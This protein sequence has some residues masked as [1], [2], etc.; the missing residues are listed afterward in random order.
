MEFDSRPT[1]YDNW[2]TMWKS[3][4]MDGVRDGS[5]LLSN[6]EIESI[7]NAF[8]ELK[9]FRRNSDNCHANDESKGLDIEAKLQ[10]ILDDL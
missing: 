1:N 7:I 3:C 5:R 4:Y 2:P 9:S 8:D 6:K 10:D